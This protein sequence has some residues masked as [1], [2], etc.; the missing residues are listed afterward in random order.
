M[1]TKFGGHHSTLLRGSRRD[2]LMFVAAA[3]LAF[4]LLIILVVVSSSRNVDATRA[5][6]P[7]TP[8][9][10][11]MAV[12][13]VTLL[14][15]S[16]LIRTGDRIQPGVI[17]EIYWPRHDV[18][19]GAVLEMAELAGK[20]AKVNINPEVPIVREQLSEQ[21]IFETLPITMGM[22]AV[23]IQVDG[24][25]GLEGWALP[26][27]KVDVAL[28]HMKD[29][30][31]TTQ[32]IVQN[33]RVLSYQGSVD[34]PM[35]RGTLS[36]KSVKTGGTLTLEVSPGD[37]LVIQ[38][39]KKLG[40]LSLI[41]RD[42]GDDVATPVS[43]IDQRHVIKTVATPAASRVCKRGSMRIE[44]REYII[45]CDGSITPLQGGVME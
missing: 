42:A 10:Q 12:G 20:F 18:P 4:S 8:Q 28:T 34:G 31:L 3:G 38:T 25:T 30:N 26:G 9:V 6:A 14:A 1:N 43:E 37:A 7:E 15:S 39:S 35:E 24:E 21:K 40:S 13:T 32:V 16:K 19:D 44:G 23:T 36:R 41:G 45:D 27:T 2:H 33:S 29:G 22:R 5:A 17:K 11:H